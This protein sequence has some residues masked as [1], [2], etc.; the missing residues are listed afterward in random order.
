MTVLNIVW[1]NVS[2]Y[3]TFLKITLRALGLIRTSAILAV[4][5]HKYIYSHS[6]N[7]TVQ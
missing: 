3:N 4:L 2:R 5:S 6:D 1:P 7:P